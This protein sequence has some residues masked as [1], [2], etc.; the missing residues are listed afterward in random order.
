MMHEAPWRRLN[1]LLPAW[2]RVPAPERET[3]YERWAI[4]AEIHARH[5]G[6]CKGLAA[7]ECDLAL[8][9]PKVSRAELFDRASEGLEEPRRVPPPG[10]KLSR[11]RHAVSLR[12][13][14]TAPSGAASWAVSTKRVQGT[15]AAIGRMAKAATMAVRDGSRYMQCDG[16]STSLPGPLQLDAVRTLVARLLEPRSFRGYL[17]QVG[18]CLSS[19]T[20]ARMSISNRGLTRDGAIEYTGCQVGAL[21]RGMSITGVECEIRPVME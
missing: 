14:P 16:R 5:P 4:P 11:C 15:R 2:R 19:E 20:L 8:R 13:W 21:A 12:G 9:D 17:L 3:E 18:R 7:A 1:D 10:K 6:P